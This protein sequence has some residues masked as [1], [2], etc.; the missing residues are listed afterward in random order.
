MSSSNVAIFGGSTG[1][2]AAVGNMDISSPLGPKV[3]VAPVSPVGPV[4]PV[5]PIGSLDPVGPSIC[6]NTLILNSGKEQY[7]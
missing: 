3:P 5:G 1:P 6:F 2:V 7:E 4:G